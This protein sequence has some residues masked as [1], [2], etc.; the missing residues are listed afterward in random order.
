MFYKLEGLMEKNKFGEQIHKLRIR[1]KMTQGE[2]GEMLGLSNKTISKWE[3]GIS[4]PD[5]DTLIKLSEIFSISLDDLVLNR[6]N[7]RITV[8]KEQ[9]EE[10]NRHDEVLENDKSDIKL[11]II[12]IILVSIALSTGICVLITSFLKE[13]GNTASFIILSLGLICVSLSLL[14][15]I[16]K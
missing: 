7:T 16:K 9:N 15:G 4:S 2:L 1:R 11:K 3:M 13:V 8:D 12:R 5:V 10:K 6:R 14:C